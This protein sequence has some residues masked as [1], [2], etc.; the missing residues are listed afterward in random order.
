MLDVTY[1]LFHGL[2]EKMDEKAKRV[3]VF[4]SSHF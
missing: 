4:F 3:T 1:V 2:D